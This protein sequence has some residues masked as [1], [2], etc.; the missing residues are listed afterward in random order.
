MLYSH[1]ILLP[2]DEIFHDLRPPLFSTALS[3]AWHVQY[4]QLAWTAMTIFTSNCEKVHRSRSSWLAARMTYF[5][6]HQCVKEGRFPYV[7]PSEESNLRY[8]T[9]VHCPKFRCREEQLWGRRAEEFLSPPELGSRRRRRVP[10]IRKVA[11]G[12]FRGAILRR[13]CGRTA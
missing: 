7:G 1:C 10:V 13:R 12:V 9:I 6:P 4:C 5:L 8:C 3:V 2:P 11:V